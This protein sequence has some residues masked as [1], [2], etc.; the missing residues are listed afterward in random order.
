[1]EKVVEAN[2]DCKG[3]IRMPTWRLRKCCHRV[4]KLYVSAEEVLTGWMI[5][6]E[7]N[8]LPAGE[9]SDTKT[10]NLTE[11]TC[12]IFRASQEK[13]KEASPIL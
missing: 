6:S 12:A 11:D 3:H 10:N 8:N 5:P 13:R 1:M 7:T 2:V 4:D 9:E